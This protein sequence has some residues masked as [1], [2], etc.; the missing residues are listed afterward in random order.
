ML[1]IQ[2]GEAEAGGSLNLR[3]VW[4]VCIVSFRTVRATHR[5]PVSHP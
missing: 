5:N 4:L 2:H 3:P 1:L